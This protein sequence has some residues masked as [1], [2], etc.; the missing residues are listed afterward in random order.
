MS[1]AAEEKTAASAEPGRPDDQAAKLRSAA[2]AVRCAEAELQKAK[3][4]YTKLR[5]QAAAQLKAMR[6]KTLG[7]VIDGTLATVRKYPVAGAILAGLLGFFCG[8]L[9]RK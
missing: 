3:E 2:D 7:N 6:Q 8:R 9:F 4:C 5:D 1:D